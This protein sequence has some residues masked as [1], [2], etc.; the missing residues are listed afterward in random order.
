MLQMTPAARPNHFCAPAS[1]AFALVPCRLAHETTT[2]NSNDKPHR[3]ANRLVEQTTDR[4]AH[5]EFHVE[6]VPKLDL[7]DVVADVLVV[8]ERRVGDL[9]VAGLDTGVGLREEVC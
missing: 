9:G 7:R 6:Q 8:E 5:S 3:H 2:K 1:L 4:H